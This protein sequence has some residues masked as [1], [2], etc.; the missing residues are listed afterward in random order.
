MYIN[1]I[2]LNCKIFY[3]FGDVDSLFIRKLKHLNIDSSRK[4][5]DGEKSSV[6]LESDFGQMS[7]Q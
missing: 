6:L 3:I 7:L 1:N 4:S 5:A 2:K